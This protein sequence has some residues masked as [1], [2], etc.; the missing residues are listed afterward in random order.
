M[1]SSSERDNHD[2]CSVC[3]GAGIMHNGMMAQLCT[4]CGGDGY[5]D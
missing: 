5:E 4:H 1:T 3:G 2:L